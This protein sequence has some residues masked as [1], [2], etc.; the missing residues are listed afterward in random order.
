MIQPGAETAISS[1]K[2]KIGLKAVQ[3]GK[4]SSGICHK[5]NI[6]IMYFE[7]LTRK[8]FARAFDSNFYTKNNYLDISMFVFLLL[9]N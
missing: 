4:F 9:K 3:M 2:G 6:S 1:G 8:L 7:A 5:I